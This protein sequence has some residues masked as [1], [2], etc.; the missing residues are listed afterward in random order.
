[1]LKKFTNFDNSKKYYDIVILEESF[2][3]QDLKKLV[4][5][6]TKSDK[7]IG[8]LLEQYFIYIVNYQREF[9]KIYDY[10]D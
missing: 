1:M 6:K 9:N 4:L 3:K 2:T 10:F 8:N 7:D 5:S